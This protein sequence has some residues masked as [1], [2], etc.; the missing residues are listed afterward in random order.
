VPEALHV[1]TTEDYDGD[2]VYFEAVLGVC[3]CVCEWHIPLS[4]CACSRVV[5]M[6]SISYACRARNRLHGH[7][8]DGAVRA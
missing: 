8:Q 4:M 1:G 7:A 3:V 2:V 5:C 6:C